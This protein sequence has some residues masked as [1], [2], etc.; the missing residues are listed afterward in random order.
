MFDKVNDSIHMLIDNTTELN[1]TRV[2]KQRNISFILVR[3][4]GSNSTSIT[5]ADL[6]GKIT[7]KG[8]CNIDNIPFNEM[9]KVTDAFMG[10]AQNV[11]GTDFDFA[12]L[13]PINDRNYSGNLYMELAN[14]NQT[15]SHRIRIDYINS[16]ILGNPIEM[17]YT[18]ENIAG[19]SSKAYDLGYTPFIFLDSNDNTKLGNIS[20]TGNITKTSYVNKDFTTLNILSNMTHRIESDKSYVLVDIE[21]MAVNRESLSMQLQTT[22]A[23]ILDIISMGKIEYTPDIDNEIKIKEPQ[24]IL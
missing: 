11:E 14:F 18:S 5:N 6:T 2:I 3:F 15:D 22:G 24:S 20:I 9:I 19:A 16:M 4:S 8:E 13:I 12:C 21:N 17:H 1:L 7:I 23:V 10:Y